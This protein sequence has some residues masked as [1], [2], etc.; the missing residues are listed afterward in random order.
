LLADASLSLHALARR[1]ERSR[2]TDPAAVFAD[3]ARLAEAGTDAGRAA[4]PGGGWLGDQITTETT[5]G[6][7]QELSVRT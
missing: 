4:V 1:Y 6:I 3:L 7:M 2:R 5:R